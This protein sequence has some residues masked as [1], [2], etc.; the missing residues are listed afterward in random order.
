M[1]LAAEIAACDRETGLSGKFIDF[2][3]VAWPKVFPA[4]PLVC[5]WHIPLIAEHYEACFRGEIRKLV[6][7]VPPGG[8]KSSI[9]CVLFP[10]W[11]WIKNPERTFIFGAY[12]QKL[13]RRDAYMQL[14]LMQSAWWQRRWPDRFRVPTVPAVEHIT[15]SKTGWRLATT[16][17]GEVTGFHA[18]YQVI[19]DPN[20]PEELTKVGLAAVRDWRSR[21][22]SS[23]W[24]RPPEI[25]SEICIMQRLHCDDLSQQL[26]DEGAVHICLPANF[27]PARRTV[28]T[29]GSDPRT[30]PGELLDEQRLP[31]QLIDDMR[32]VLGPI[33]AAAQLDQ[34]P[35]PE[36]GA[37]FKRE[38]LK[39]W[40]T[41]R[42]PGRHD[43]FGDGK[44][45]YAVVARPDK[46]DQLICSWDC[47]FKDEEENDFVAGQVWGRKDAN[48]FLID[49][50]HAHLDFP[51]TV[52]SVLELARRHKLAIVKLVEDKANGPAVVSTLTTKV[53]GI[54][55]VDPRG[56]KYSRASACAGLFEAGNVY[57][58][59][60]LSYPWVSDFV[61]EFLSFPRAKHDDQVDAATQALLYL[62]EHTSYLKAAMDKVRSMAGFTVRT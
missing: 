62:Q 18:N 28:T 58:P 32:K 8:S 4:S 2:I 22:M 52:R 55:A 57:L 51:G 41:G 25:N 46:F 45:T 30:K 10:A 16:P 12:G 20:K 26:L 39:F 50:I 44:G 37:V 47:A 38:H 59:D 40:S 21:T 23:R 48:F 14:A 19:D 27:D 36:G 33:N 42:A 56:G 54:I 11:V 6:V 29:Y 31:Q 7:N 61:A 24:R 9:T 15:N 43:V 3:K 49:Q 35:V 5:N 34:S 53:P 17:G 13:I 60:P 1:S